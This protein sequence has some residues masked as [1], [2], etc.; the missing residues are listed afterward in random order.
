VLALLT[1]KQRA[2][3][4]TEHEKVMQLHKDVDKGYG[5]PHVGAMK[6]NPHKGGDVAQPES[7]SVMYLQ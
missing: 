2:K 5:N 1:P 7:I 4:K 6:D 3:E